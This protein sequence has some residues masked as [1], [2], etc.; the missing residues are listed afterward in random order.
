MVQCPP[1]ASEAFRSS[2][3]DVLGP[4]NTVVQPLITLPAH[5]YRLVPCLKD[6]HFTPLPENYFD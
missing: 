3:D 5:V 1:L 2:I 6:D 4:V